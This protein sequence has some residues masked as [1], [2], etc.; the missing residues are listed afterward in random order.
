LEAASRTFSSKL[1]KIA[2]FTP[3]DYDLTKVIPCVI[4]L[5]RLASFD[6]GARAARLDVS[7][8]G[9]CFGAR[10]A[11]TT[12]TQTISIF[13]TGLS[14]SRPSSGRTVIIIA[15]R[16]VGAN[17]TSAHTTLVFACLPSCRTRV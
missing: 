5:L 10:C 1:E 14:G 11:C 8:G 9:A 6:G 2:M 4:D 15:S 17:R 13:F 7:S 16:I 12:V 3:L